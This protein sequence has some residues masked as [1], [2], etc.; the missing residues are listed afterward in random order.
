MVRHWA[1]AAGAF[2]MV[3]GTAVPA[4]ADLKL[5]NKTTSNV[6]VAIGYKDKDGWATEGWWKV[7]PQKCLQF[8]HI[9]G[10]QSPPK[11]RSIVA[12]VTPIG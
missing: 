9:R 12:S 8:P 7:L 3:C 11:W 6:G 2:L 1:I 10:L 5:C 4:Y